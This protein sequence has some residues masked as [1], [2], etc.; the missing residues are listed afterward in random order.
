MSFVSI[1]QN[2]TIPFND[3]A[4]SYRSDR[5][6]TRDAMLRLAQMVCGNASVNN[7][8]ALTHDGYANIPVNYYISVSFCLCI[9]MGMKTGEE[10]GRLVA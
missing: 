3:V 9:C 8:C 2:Q 6:N 10:L 7:I 4:A 5:A 1:P